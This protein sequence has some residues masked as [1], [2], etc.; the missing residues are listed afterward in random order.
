MA[1]HLDSNDDVVQRRLQRLEGKYRRAQIL[2][3]GAQAIQASLRGLPTAE[4]RQKHVAMQQV[5][6][7]RQA[8]LDVQ[9]AID[10]LEDQVSAA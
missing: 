9:I 1:R 10:Q 6:A 3:A 8:L 5:Q 2:L 4:E 7:A